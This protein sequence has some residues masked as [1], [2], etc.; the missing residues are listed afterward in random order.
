VKIAS[1][2]KTDNEFNLPVVFQ[3][4]RKL[5]K[6]TIFN[7]INEEKSQRI[8]HDIFS[9]ENFHIEETENISEVIDKKI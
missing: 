5:L 1:I 7:G 3:N 6:G 4:E 8:V 9:K 2:Q